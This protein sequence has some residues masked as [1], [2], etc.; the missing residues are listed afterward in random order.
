MGFII[1]LVIVIFA[2]IKIAIGISKSSKPYT[3]SSESGTSYRSYKQHVDCSKLM[4]NYA[5]IDTETTGLDPK[6]D[7][8]IQ[9][10]AVIYRNHSEYEA[11]TWLINPGMHIPEEASSINGIYDKDVEGKPR[12]DDVVDEFLD[13]IRGYT[14]LGYN[15]SFDRS[16]I[17]NEM[18]ESLTNDTFDVYWFAKTSLSARNYKLTTV[19]EKL[20]ISTAGAHNALYDCFM[21]HKVFEA[22]LKEYENIGHY[23]DVSTFSWNK[24]I[25][26]FSKDE[27][28]IPD[29]PNE[30]NP[31]YKKRFVFTG[32]LPIRRKAALQRIINLGAEFNNTVV[33][34]SDFLVIGDMPEP[35]KKM[36][37]ANKLIAEG[38]PLR[39]ISGNDFMDMLIEAESFGIQ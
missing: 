14:L 23:P 18:G 8:I 24:Y 7:K 11:R 4:P 35:S 3:H 16:I 34:R 10:S 33:K 31:F 32:T 15:I 36:E 6:K 39:I 26:N 19:A 38:S 27:F 37:N 28:K 20:G 25:R 5:V 21:T 12:F 29:N 22:L 17:S 2:V 1:F 9:L 30:A 13:L